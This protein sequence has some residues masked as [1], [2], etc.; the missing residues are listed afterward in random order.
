MARNLVLWVIIA[1]VLMLVFQQFAA[2]PAGVNEIEYSEFLR[3]IKANKVSQLEI[4]QQNGTVEGKL[5][6]GTPFLTY[7]PETDNNALLGLLESTRFRSTPP[8]RTNRA[9]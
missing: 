2:S 8:D 9:C 5:H 1:L 7:S 4:D 6:D 3:A